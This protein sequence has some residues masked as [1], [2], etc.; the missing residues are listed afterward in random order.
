MCRYASTRHVPTM[1]DI[2][3]LKSVVRELQPLD[4][5]EVNYILKDSFA[6]MFH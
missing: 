5:E 4:I 2:D 3:L 6:G 1:D